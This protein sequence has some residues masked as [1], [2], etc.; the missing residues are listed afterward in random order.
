MST[1]FGMPSTYTDKETKPK[2]YFSGKWRAMCDRCGYPFLNTQLQEEKLT[3]LMVCNQCV[4]PLPYD[5]YW[6]VPPEHP[7]PDV[8]RPRQ[9]Q[10]NP[11]VNVPICNPTGN[12]Y[13]L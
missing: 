7:T 2:G 13:D 4:D 1:S 11:N 3:R 5:Y 8:P 10:V 9:D 6:Q 12:Y